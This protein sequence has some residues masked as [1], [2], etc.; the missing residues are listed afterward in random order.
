MYLQITEKCNMT[1]QHCCFSCNRK[2]KHA[3]FN[4]ILQAMDFISQYDD[5][6]ISIGGGE[7]TLHPRFFDII[8]HALYRFNYVW[9][10]TNGS[11]SKTMFRLA[12]IIH[13]EDY[14]NQDEFIDGSDGKLTVALSTD[15]FHDPINQQV[16]EMWGRYSLSRVSGFELRDVTQSSVGVIGVGRAKKHVTEERPDCTCNEFI[17]KVD[18]TIKACGCPE[19]PIIGDVF[20][21]DF[22]SDYIDVLELPSFYNTRCWTQHLKEFDEGLGLE[23]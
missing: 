12:D 17:V 5:E 14:D 20:S 2:G 10:A 8:K 22:Y 4:L 6:F 21:T 3:D 16:R 11:K 18:G 9:M 15:Y 19:A 13:G 7:P 23:N 1:C